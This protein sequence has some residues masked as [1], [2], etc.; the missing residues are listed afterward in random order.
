MLK[1]TCQDTCKYIFKKKNA[2]LP[3]QGEKAYFF[4]LKKSKSLSNML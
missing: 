2:K 1:I 3:V 4:L